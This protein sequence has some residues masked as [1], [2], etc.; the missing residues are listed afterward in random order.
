MGLRAS[1]QHPRFWEPLIEQLRDTYPGWTN[2]SVPPKD[3]WMDLPSGKSYPWDSVA[4]TGDQKL[5]VELYVDN[6]QPAAQ[7]HLW[8]QLT[9]AR[10]TIEAHLPS[11]SWE[12]SITDRP[13]LPL[14]R[15]RRPRG[16]LG[17]LPELAA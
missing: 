6:Q 12:P 7:Q 1:R 15:Q 11:L 2:T 14:R 16:R 10:D 5:R 8:Q 4:F 9:A 17:D 3:S 13:L